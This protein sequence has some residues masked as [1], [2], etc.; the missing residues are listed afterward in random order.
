MVDS[1]GAFWIYEEAFILSAAG[2]PASFPTWSWS[3]R[4]SGSDM[5]L[6]VHCAWAPVMS[7]FDE[8]G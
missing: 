6:L 7:R 1:A 2:R 4:L 3:D 5:R 8:L